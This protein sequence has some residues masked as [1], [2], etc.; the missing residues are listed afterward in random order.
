MHG[1]YVAAEDEDLVLRKRRVEIYRRPMDKISLIYLQGRGI[2]VSVD[3]QVKLAEHDVPV[4]AR[5]ALGQSCCRGKS[6]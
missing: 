3:A 5:S 4:S 1:T 6:D 2:S